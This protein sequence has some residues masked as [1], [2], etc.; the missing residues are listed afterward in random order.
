MKRAATETA[1]MVGLGAGKSV[2]NLVFFGGCKL[3]WAHLS[4][5]LIVPLVVV[6]HM[7]EMLELLGLL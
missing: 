5:L 2:P 3:F 7:E 6:D 4:I 1:E